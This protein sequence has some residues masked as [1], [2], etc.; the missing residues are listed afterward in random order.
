MQEIYLITGASRGIGRSLSLELANS[1]FTVIGLSRKSPEL[2]TLGEKLKT[3]GSDSIIV[4]CDLSSAEDIEI[5]T[6]KI[7]AKYS[8]LDGIVHNAGIINPIKSMKEVEIDNWNHLIQVNLVGVQNLTQ[9]LYPLMIGSNQTRVTTISSG[10]SKHPIGS[11]SAYCVSKAGLD[12]WARC[13]AEEGKEHNISAISVAPGIVDTNMQKKIRSS[14]PDDFPLHPHFVD[15]HDTGQ[16]V[17]PD[18]VAKQLFS[19]VTTHDMEQTGGRFD[20]REL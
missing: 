3:I 14:N 6:K 19:L 17:E 16:L 2:E 4:P 13:L 10:A 11:W 1:G 15:Y 7:T 8:Q 5:A 18:L 20:V 12:M 9:K